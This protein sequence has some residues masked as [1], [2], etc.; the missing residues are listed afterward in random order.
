M[1]PQTKN[2]KAVALAKRMV[3]YRSYSAALQRF[4]KLKNKSVDTLPQVGIINRKAS[5]ENKI[6]QAISKQELAQDLKF[7]EENK[8]QQIVRTPIFQSADTLAETICKEIS[9][10]K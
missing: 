10:S 2:P 1:E 8:I 4:L 3:T 7:I 9:N 6:V 5:S